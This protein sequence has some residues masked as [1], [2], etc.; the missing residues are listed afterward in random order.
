MIYLDT[1]VVVALLTPEER[2][3]QAL[4]WFAESREPLIS[5]IAT[6]AP[7]DAETI[8][9]LH[10]TLRALPRPPVP[11]GSV[12][13]E[14]Q[15]GADGQEKPPAQPLT[16]GGGALAAVERLYQNHGDELKQLADA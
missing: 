11:R 6:D 8:Q 15:G 14:P 2:S 13:L 3:A 12:A 10:S 16:G 4:D 7:L 1:S 5:L 9:H